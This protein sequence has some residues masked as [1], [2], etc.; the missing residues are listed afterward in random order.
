M[1][2]L[3]ARNPLPPLPPPHPHLVR[4]PGPEGE[5]VQLL[6]LGGLGHEGDGH[7]GEGGE[8]PQE[9][10]KVEVVDVVHH[11]VPPLWRLRVVAAACRL[12][13]PKLEAEPEDEARFSRSL[14]GM[15]WAL[16]V[17]LHFFNNKK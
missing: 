9:E 3:T 15:S 11:R 12:G 6:L 2:S 14:T 17:F 8:A 7:G 13:V 4:V 5:P 10:A 1:P 16:E